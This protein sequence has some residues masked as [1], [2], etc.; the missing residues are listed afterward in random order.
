MDQSRAVSRI[1]SSAIRELLDL[2]HRPG[3]ISLAG[4]LPSPLHFPVDETRRVV[5]ELLCDE[6]WHYA[7]GMFTTFVVS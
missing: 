7:N 1:S 6:P 4:G 5:D 3:I 2:V